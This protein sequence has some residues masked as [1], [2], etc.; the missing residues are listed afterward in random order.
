MPGAS[1]SLVLAA[2]SATLRDATR[3]T[4][5]LSFAA[6]ALTAAM[7]FAGPALAQG[8]PGNPGN[9]GMMTAPGEAPIDLPPGIGPNGERLQP[10]ID[11]WFRE[12]ANAP[13]ERVAELA[14]DHIQRDWLKSGSATADLLLQWA[15]EALEDEEFATALDLLDAAIV[16]KPDFAEAW[17]KRATAYYML[18]DYGRA[19]SDLEHTLALEPR[20]F[21]AIA[22]LGIIL[23]DVGREPEALE[24]LREAL[25][26]HPFLESIPKMV[27]D[28]TRETGRDL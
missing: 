8:S 23:A 28:L 20:H 5:R 21:G 14:A 16:M 27:A 22:G 12:L 18:D 9:P 10:M 4:A 17:N 26:I 6:V 13:N 3:G 24:V 7:A 19:L 11:D 15:I 25:K 1:L 2:A